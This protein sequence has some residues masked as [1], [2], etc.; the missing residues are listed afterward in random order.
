[1]NIVLPLLFLFIWVV[2][3]VVPIVRILR[4]LGF[5]EWLAVIALIPLGNLFGLWAIAFSE[6]P[7][8]EATLRART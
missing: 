1:M 7:A 2:L 3:V 4:R 6:W 5:N 8:I